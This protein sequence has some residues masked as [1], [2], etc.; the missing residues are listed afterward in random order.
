[1]SRSGSARGLHA[2]MQRYVDGDKKAFVE[3]RA[4]VDPRLRGFLSSRVPDASVDDLMQVT[5]LKAHLARA[6]FRPRS[7]EDPD[8]S[9]LAWYFAIARN[10][11]HDH[12]RRQTRLQQ[13]VDAS[14][15][16]EAVVSGADAPPTPEESWAQSQEEQ[17]IVDRVHAA[18]AA[19]SPKQREVVELHKLQE[20]SM[21]EI[22]QRLK[23]REG[24][25]RVRAHRA[26]RA[27]AALLSRKPSP[28]DVR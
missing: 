7:P 9:V 18:I 22:A 11:A 19:L 3:L 20:L 5:M 25:V 2:L 16:V 8:G 1:M 17:E 23:I 13:R 14:G 10:A 24:A 15:D 4:L 28:G 21:A 27:L 12:L 6:R 26:Y